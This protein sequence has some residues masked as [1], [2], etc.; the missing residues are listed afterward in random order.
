MT[1]FYYFSLWASPENLD[2]G[3]TTSH[4]TET[5]FSPMK[6]KLLTL[7][8]LISIGLSAMLYWKSNPASP[9]P[10][11]GG[12]VSAI[13]GPDLVEH[14]KSLK[15]P[16]VLVNFWASWCAPCKAEFPILISLREKWAARGLQVVFVS[17]DEPDDLPAAEE[18]LL[19]VGVKF[20]TYFKGT[21][22]LSFIR[23]LFPKWQGSVPASLLYGPNAELLEAWEGESSADELE[24]RV[25]QKLKGT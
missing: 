15:S 8:L 20:P 14:I 1:C 3:L 25:A 16:L 22:E 9:T 12:Q 23:E 13:S 21:Q 19:Q 4:A 11:G 10:S 24:A 2:K 5:I 7:L 17:I 18:F 6:I